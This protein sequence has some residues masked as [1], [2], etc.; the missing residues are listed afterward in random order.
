MVFSN[1]RYLG[2]K[3]QE[4]AK[5]AVHILCIG[6]D[7]DRFAAPYSKPNRCTILCTR[8]FLPVYNNE[9]LI[10]SLALI[11]RSATYDRVI[12]SSTGP[13]LDSCKNMAA[14]LLPHKIR[15]K[16]F[17]LEGLTA[18]D[19]ITCLMQASIFVS[20]AR[21]DGTPISLL[22]AMSCGLFP[23]VS[24]IPQNR[25]WIHP[26]LGNGILVP[27]DQPNK[28][29]NAL[30]TAIRDDALRDRAIAVNRKMI[31]EKA[32]SRINMAVLAKKMEELIEIAE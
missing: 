30:E 22:E 18:E 11:S 1:G 6:V 5:R 15:E 14:Q 7:T 8:G 21:S 17:F 4:L 16:V 26:E 31:T 19:L 23:V 9:Y 24:D 12:F 25:E 13:T 32:N 20:M 29:A 3:T 10:K 28:L 2:Y 27:L